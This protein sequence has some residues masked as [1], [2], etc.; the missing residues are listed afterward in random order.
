MVDTGV[1]PRELIAYLRPERRRTP[2]QCRI[3]PATAAV[4]RFHPFHQVLL[5]IT[6]PRRGD[7]WRPVAPFWSESDLPSPAADFP[8]IGCRQEYEKLARRPRDFVF[9][10]LPPRP[11]WG[12][13]SANGRGEDI[14]LRPKDGERDTGVSL[15]F[16]EEVA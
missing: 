16:Y 5:L 11:R 9:L 2:L 10:K 3:G 15:S 12:H 7:A 8:E 14:P 4:G 6:A 1:S 13:S